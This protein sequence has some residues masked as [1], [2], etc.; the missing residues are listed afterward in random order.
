LRQTAK[1]FSVRRST[2]QNGGTK[3]RKDGKRKTLYGKL[4][5]KKTGSLDKDYAL[6]YPFLENCKAAMPIDHMAYI[7]HRTERNV[8]GTLVGMR[9]R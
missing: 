4:S 9:P 5:R 3:K 8:S 7:L 6:W 1:K 2:T